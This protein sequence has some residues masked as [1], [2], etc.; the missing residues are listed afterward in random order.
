MGSYVLSNK[1]KKFKIVVVNK[2]D[3]YSAEVVLVLVENIIWTAM[4]SF[5][6]HEAET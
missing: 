5:T 1:V 6:T 3:V 4:H 2:C